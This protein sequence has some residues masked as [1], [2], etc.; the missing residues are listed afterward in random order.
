MRNTP[1]SICGTHLMAR[2]R[3]DNQFRHLATA[4]T[5]PNRS[6]PLRSWPFHHSVCDRPLISYAFNFKGTRFSKD[7][8]VPENNITCHVWNESVFRLTTDTAEQILSARFSCQQII[9]FALT[10]AYQLS[11]DALL[12]FY[13]SILDMH[14]LWLNKKYKRSVQWSNSL[15]TKVCMIHQFFYLIR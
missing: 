9:F 13:Y 7:A 2:R 15:N 8:D 3:E 14:F 1:G 10:I 4:H 12:S 6:P 5:L 11:N